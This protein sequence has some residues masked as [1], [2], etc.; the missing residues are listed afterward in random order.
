M[1]RDGSGIYSL[2]AGY[3]A[4]TGEVITAAQHNTPLEDVATGLTIRC[5]ATA[6]LQ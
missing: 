2:P 6:S 5:R 1:P 3:L 4:V